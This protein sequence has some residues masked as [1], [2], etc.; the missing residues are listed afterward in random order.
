MNQILIN[1]NVSVPVTPGMIGLFF[2]DINYNLDGGLHAEMLENRNFEALRVT[3]YWDDY[4]TEQDGLYAWS[5]SGNAAISI[6]TE[7]PQ[8]EVNPHYLR[9]T[10]NEAGAGVSN[11]AYDGIYMEAA[12]SYELTFYARAEKM[13]KMDIHVSDCAWSTIIIDGDGQWKQYRVTLKA[14][15]MLEKG[16][17]KMLLKEEGTIDLDLVSL[18]PKDAVRGIFRKDL[19]QKLKDLKPGFLRFPGGCII[20]GNNLA[21]R[22]Q[23]KKTVGPVETRKYNWN[24]WAIHG[25]DNTPEKKGD[26]FESPYSHYGQTYGV[27]YYEYFLLSEELGAKPLPVLSVGLACQYQSTELVPI[28]TP[29]F[30]EF[31]QDALDLI[32]FAN[33]GVDTT[34]GRVRAEMGHPEPFNMDLIGI[35]NEQWQT[36][37][38]DFFERYELF[39][40]AIHEKYPEMRLIGSA[41]PDVKTPRYEEAWKWL[42]KSVDARIAAQKEDAAIPDFVYAVDEHYYVRPAWLYE[43]VHFY[44]EYPRT[45]KVFAGEYAA[46]VEGKGGRFN[47]PQSN[48]F[49]AALAEA[50]FLTGV[51][52]NADVVVMASYA[53]LIARLDYAQWSPDLIWFNGAG[54]YGTPSYYVQQLYSLYMGD[55]SMQVAVDGMDLYASATYDSETG[56]YIV[57]VVNSDAA[58]QKVCLVL[59]DL[60]GRTVEAQ[61]IAMVCEDLQAV[62]SIQKPENI[63]PVQDT[64]TIEDGIVELAG[65]SFNVFV[66]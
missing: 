32:E 60:K 6:E 27:G 44:D 11:K 22:Y 66:I 58:P 17:F 3:G 10:A 63:A 38:A 18:M 8:N 29:E 23:W 36:D 45:V 47:S 15:R 49:E 7:N 33:G 25:V 61:R 14:G 35:G 1:K 9:L 12:E 57:K 56:K 55:R 30:Q 43:N 20:E 31:I 40:K 41:G 46:H 62:N 4:R 19:V 52:R 37:K 34:W 59:E 54:C 5:A 48:N 13:N 51:E 28:D 26:P 39:E 2:E 42:H 53:P 16:T 65:Q 50:A 24:R 64:V 21:N